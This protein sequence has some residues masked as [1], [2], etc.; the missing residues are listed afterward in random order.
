MTATATITTTYRYIIIFVHT[1]NALSPG[2]PQGPANRLVDGEQTRHFL[3]STFRYNKE[4]CL[5]PLKT[6][7]LPWLRGRKG[8]G[9]HACH[10]IESWDVETLTYHL[11]K[12]INQLVMSLIALELYL[13]PYWYLEACYRYISVDRRVLLGGGIAH[14]SHTI[15]WLPY[16][17]G[18]WARTSL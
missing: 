7:S 13:E 8:G 3:L 15:T 16:I 1:K 2:I 12:T 17:K 6:I 18:S 10:V 4:T 5:R 14:E 9:M 11:T